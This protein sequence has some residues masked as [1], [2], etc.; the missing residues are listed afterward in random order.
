MTQTAIANRPKCES[1]EEPI[2]MDLKSPERETYEHNFCGVWY[3]CP[4]CSGSVL[5][6]SP[7]LEAQLSEQRRQI[8][9]R[10]L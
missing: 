7:E 8:K 9:A 6:T 4:K 2:L 1:H 10:L 5:Y 3:N